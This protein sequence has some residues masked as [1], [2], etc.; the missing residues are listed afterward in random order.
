M[1]HRSLVRENSG[2]IGL[3]GGKKV[4]QCAQLFLTDSRD[5]QK[6][7]DVGVSER[8]LEH[9]LRFVIASRCKKTPLDHT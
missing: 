7:K 2:I 1:S 6:D 4:K 3:P 9:I 5:Y 8:E